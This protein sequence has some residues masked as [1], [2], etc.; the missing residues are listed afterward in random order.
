MP[1]RKTLNGGACP[2]GN[3]EILIHRNEIEYSQ[4][5]A[6]HCFSCDFSDTSH[7][8]DHDKV[9]QCPSSMTRQN[10]GMLKSLFLLASETREK[11]DFWDFVNLYHK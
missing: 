5:P 6:F 10:Y 11:R 8:F 3:F 7:D 1:V 4:N 9:C 2:L